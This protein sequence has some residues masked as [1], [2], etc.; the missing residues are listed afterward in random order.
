MQ[1]GELSLEAGRG[2][3]CCLPKYQISFAYNAALSYMKRETKLRPKTIYLAGPDV[4]KTDF[5]AIRDRLKSLCSAAGFI[6][7]SPADGD[8]IDCHPSELSHQIY[9]QN[10]R[11]IDSADIVMANVEHFRGLEPDSGTVFEIGYAIGRGKLVWCYNVP[12]V[13]LIYQV[14]CDKAHIDADGNA[15]ENFGLPTNLMLAHACHLVSG[16]ANTCIH[17]I[18]NFYRI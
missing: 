2:D 12:K 18:V 1:C 15:V 16:D 6:P 11:L 8:P 5:V 3:V 4:F 7:L 9:L 14:P 10:V 13:S 17:E